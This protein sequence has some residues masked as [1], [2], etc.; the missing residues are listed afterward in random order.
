MTWE[1]LRQMLR[2]WYRRLV[3]EP[4]VSKKEIIWNLWN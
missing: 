1:I 3:T 2:K 4:V